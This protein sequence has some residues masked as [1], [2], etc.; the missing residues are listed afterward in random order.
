MLVGSVEKHVPLL[1]ADFLVGLEGKE[2]HTEWLSKCFE[3]RDAS[4]QYISINVLRDASLQYI[5]FFKLFNSEI[6]LSKIIFENS[7]VIQRI[8]YHPSM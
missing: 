3:L 7:G 4:L 1:E 5:H 6:S 8:H 2:S